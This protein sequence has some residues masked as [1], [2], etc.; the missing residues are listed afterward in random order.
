MSSTQ[1][2]ET[3]ADAYKRLFETAL[4]VLSSFVSAFV[5]ND[6][7]VQYNTVE[8]TLLVIF[9]TIIWVFI[10]RQLRKLFDKYSVTILNR[11]WYTWLNRF[12][13]FILLLAIFLVAQF[14]LVAV[15]AAVDDGDLSPYESLAFILSGMGVA[16]FFGISLQIAFERLDDPVEPQP[17][18][19]TQQ[20]YYYLA[21]PPQFRRTHTRR[22]MTFW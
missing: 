19:T 22:E 1:T 13:N 8:I 18:L 11:Q 21:P 5:F 14:I 4:A 10:D 9:A 12:L 2:R 16:F 6:I 3:S 20:H 15:R 7:I 17:A